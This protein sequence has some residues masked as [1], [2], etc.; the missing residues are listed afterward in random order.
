MANV[1]AMK[2]GNWSKSNALN[3]EFN[4]SE[5]KKK[6]LSILSRRRLKKKQYACFFR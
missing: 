6:S 4:K 5:P 2:S 3:S 1:T